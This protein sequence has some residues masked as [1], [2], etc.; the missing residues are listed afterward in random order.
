MLKKLSDNKLAC[1][2]ENSLIRTTTKVEITILDEN[3]NAPNFDT[4]VGPENVQ[5][6]SEGNWG[7]TDETGKK[8]S[9]SQITDRDEDLSNTRTCFRI[10]DSIGDGNDLAATSYFQVASSKLNDRVFKAD[11]VLEKE[12]GDEIENRHDKVDEDGDHYNFQFEVQVITS[13]LSFNFYI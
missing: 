8:I 3:I 7:Q 2:G 4:Y 12:F 5:K 6:L 9:L 10:I 11:L 1:C 13:R